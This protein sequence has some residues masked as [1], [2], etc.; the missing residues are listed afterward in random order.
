MLSIYKNLIK[1]VLFQLDAEVVHNGVTVLGESLEKI[2]PPQFFS[3]HDPKL[4]QN[5]CGLNFPNPLGLS[6]GFDYDGHLAQVMPRVGFGFNT[7]GTVTAKAYEG[8][9]PPRLGRLPRSKALFVNK[10]FKSEGVVAVAAR[11]AQK[12]L[13]NAIV[14]VSIGSSNLPEVNTINKAIDDYLFSFSYLRN[15]NFVSYLE[16]NISCPNTLLPEPFTKEKNLVTLLGQIKK[17]NL[18]KPLFIKMPNEILLEKAKD[19]VRRA[20]EYPVAGFIFSNLVKDRHNRFLDKEELAK[21]NGLKGNFSGLPTRENSDGL[22]GSIYQKFGR[23]CVLVGC[24]G[25]FTAADAYRK[26]KLGASLVQ[27]ATGLI[28]E[29]PGITG[30]IDRG[31]AKFLER[32]GFAHISEA[33][34]ADFSG[35]ATIKLSKAAVKKYSRMAD[36]FKAKK[37]IFSAGS[38]EELMRDLQA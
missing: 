25:I 12:D 2:L 3:C 28:F 32:D 13:K 4:I 1:P 36:D 20:L 14:G 31:L 19:L 24:G 21:F 10:G 22:I 6:A 15:K 23:D 33:V 11:L 9:K 17:L 8:N 26:I 35:K 30:D 29:G 5:I 7:V 37:N 34:G 27:M 18:K 38:V 16:L